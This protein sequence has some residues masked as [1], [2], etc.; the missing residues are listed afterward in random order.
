MHLEIRK[1]PLL[2]VSGFIV[3][4]LY[5][6]FTFTAWAL[7][8]DSFTPW[9]HYLSRLGDFDY[10]PVGAYFYNLGCI[11]AGI[12]L[13]P[14]FIGLCKWYGMH[15]AARAV[16]IVGQ[17]LGILAAC[18]LMMIGVYSE[19]L[20]SP[21]MVAS[22]DFFLLN[23][24]VMLIINIALLFNS[25]F[26]KLIGL[27]GI[28]MTLLSLPLEIYIGGSLIEWYTVFGS[29]V[30]VGLLSFNTISISKNDEPSTSQIQA[31]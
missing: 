24:F 18:A 5:C 17:V 9:T 27:Y 16:L 26:F 6:G 4:I 22:A 12:A 21:H 11:L 8:P 1:R 25:R 28:V 10:S 2:S 29:L 15:I 13:I 30:F 3:I 23:F 19:N 14:F 20:G 7:Y 31:Q